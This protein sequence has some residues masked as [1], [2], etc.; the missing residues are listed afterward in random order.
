MLGEFPELCLVLGTPLV[1][2]FVL[3]PPGRAAAVGTRTPVKEAMGKG[4]GERGA[5]DAGLL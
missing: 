1:S 5:S 4:S 3:H 2:P